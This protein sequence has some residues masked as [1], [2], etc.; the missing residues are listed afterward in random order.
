MYLIKIIK[1]KMVLN[2]ETI[3]LWQYCMFELSAHELVWKS[4]TIY[5]KETTYLKQ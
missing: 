4:W 3:F 1:I 2:A 5:L